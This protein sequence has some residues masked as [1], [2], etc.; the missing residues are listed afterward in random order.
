MARYKGLEDAQPA[1]TQIEDTE[2]DPGRREAMAGGDVS[3][4]AER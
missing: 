1:E 3:R 4:S 2:G